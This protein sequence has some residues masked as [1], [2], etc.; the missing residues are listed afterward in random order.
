MTEAL[1]AVLPWVAAATHALGF[2]KYHSQAKAGTSK[3]NFVSWAIWAFLATLN[4]LSFSVITSP[5]VAAQTYV[6]AMGAIGIF[7]Y[8][9]ISGK[10]AWPSRQEQIV[11]V[12]SIIDDC[13]LEAF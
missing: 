12:I 6:G 1:A 5:V 8:A 13:S 9:L 2:W 3:P 7:I 10:F 4:A 11:C